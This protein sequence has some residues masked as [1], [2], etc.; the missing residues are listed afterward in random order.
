M[1]QLLFSQT[2]Y[3]A[4]KKDSTLTPARFAMLLAAFDA[5]P[6]RAAAQYEQMRRALVAFFEYRESLEPEQDADETFDRAARRLS[7]SQ[8]ITSANPANFFYGIARNVWRERLA[9]RRIA[10]PLDEAEPHT[11]ITPHALLEE[12]ETQQALE[13][14]LHC[15]RECLQTLA[16]DDRELLLAYYREQG[17]AKI[18]LRRELARELGIEVSVLRLRLF[19]LR[20]KL[21]VSVKRCLY[22]KHTGSNGVRPGGAQKS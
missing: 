18:E 8:Q 11:W 9:A 4:L 22:R 5:E 19:R 17:Q 10:V 16:L 15:L 13:T 6:E 7:E 20:A 12:R 2:S 3:D 14:R 1:K 21:E